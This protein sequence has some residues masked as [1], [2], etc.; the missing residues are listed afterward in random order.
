MNKKKL[1]GTTGIATLVLSAPFAAFAYDNTNSEDELKKRAEHFQGM[2][3]EE[4]AETKLNVTKAVLALQIEHANELVEKL[5]ENST[6]D[7]ER[8][9]ELIEEY[10]ALEESLDSIEIDEDLK[11][12]L[13]ESFFEIKQEARE[14]SKEFKEIIKDSFTEEER[15][16]LREEFKAEMNEIR[17]AYGLPEKKHKYGKGMNKPRF[18]EEIIAQISPETAE[19][20]E[21]EEIEFRDAMKEIK[22]TLDEMSEEERDALFE[23]LGI[24]KPQKR[25]GERSEGERPQRGEMN[26][27]RAHF[28]SEE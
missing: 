26:E 28:S 1:I 19:K 11:E 12:D 27:K 3:F 6:A 14:I 9:N 13:R 7:K 20:L 15:E 21:N 18:S 2:S 4:V 24:E 22:S 10:A 16:E 25:Q 8:L 17:E 23:E 5:D